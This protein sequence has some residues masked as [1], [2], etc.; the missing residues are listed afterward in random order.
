MSDPCTSSFAIEERTPARQHLS[1]SRSI[2]QR[3]VST[4]PTSVASVCSYDH[5]RYHEDDD[6]TCTE[7]DGKLQ[8]FRLSGVSQSGSIRSISAVVADQQQRSHTPIFAYHKSGS[9]RSISAVAADQQRPVTPPPAESGIYERSSFRSISAVVHQQRSHTPPP[10][11]PRDESATT[12]SS[13]ILELSPGWRVRLRGAKETQAAVE[14]DF[15][16]PTICHGCQMDILCIRDANYVVCPACHV[17][18]PLDDDANMDY[19]HGGLGLGFTWENVQ[20]WQSQI[21]M[22]RGLQQEH[23]RRYHQQWY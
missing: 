10:F 4:S 5:S 9:F 22:A 17:V 2:S 19:C 23:C 16:L 7:F 14:G 12:T 15:Y 21:V 11:T 20:E 18:S 8:A 3:L 1:E 13:T 6:D